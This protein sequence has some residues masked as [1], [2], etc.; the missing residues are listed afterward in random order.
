VNPTG[1]EAYK[2]IE[3]VDHR[4]YVG[5][6]WA[7]PELAIGTL[8]DPNTGLFRQPQ[9][10]SNATSVERALAVA[11]RSYFTGELEQISEDTRVAVLSAW[12]DALEDHAPRI[13]RE[14]A[15]ATGNPLSTT[16]LLASYLGARV[17]SAAQ[18]FLELAREKTL[19][20]DGR[21]VRVLHKPLGPALILAPWNAPTFVGVSKVAN[22]LAAG[23]PVLLKPSEWAPGGCQ[24]AAEALV[25]IL[26]R[27]GF[28]PGAFQ[29]LHGGSTTGAQ[30]SSD[31]RV[32]VLSFTGGA[33][34]GH[35]VARAA[36]GSFALTQ[37][38]LGS[39]NPAIVMPDADV[40]ATARSLVSGMTRL[41]GQWCEAP[42]KVLIS[43]ALYDDVVDALRVEIG[44]VG[45]GHCLEP[46][47]EVGP[48]AYEGH[49]LGLKS[50]LASLH[51]AGG[52][53]IAEAKLPDLG[54][55]FIAP[56]LVV[57]L[58]AG[59]ARDELFGPILTL[60]RVGTTEEALKSA[61]GPGGGLAAFVFGTDEERA[62]EVACRIH[63][64]EVRINGTYMSDLADG[65]EQSFWGTS[66]V[67]GHGPHYGVRSFLGNRV[68]GVDAN[69]FP[70]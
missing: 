45:I 26:D 15:L 70:I 33:V 22:A 32:A 46:T 67:G 11:A 16:T 57:G 50:Q 25:E 27:F 23:C 8:C 69:Q 7:T 61:N 35:A 55:W 13:A 65:S 59:Q 54:G 44:L 3:P 37:L 2:K 38:E 60:H 41:N 14:D 21:K 66:G 58:D 1:A 4:E 48:L 39:N 24:I 47:T 56:S 42:G 49:L 28:P 9:R 17:R 20:A 34:A 62:F 40:A 18:Q 19:P 52:S 68:V 64:G 63:A 10:A 43:A 51:D 30:L 36:A 6:D 12:A 53:I 29:L 5:G 31:P